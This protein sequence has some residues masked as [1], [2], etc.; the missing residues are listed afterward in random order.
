[1]K[2]ILNFLR[3]FFEDFLKNISH[4]EVTKTI[5]KQARVAHVIPFAPIKF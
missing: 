2:T 1:M 4:K 5:K 3:D